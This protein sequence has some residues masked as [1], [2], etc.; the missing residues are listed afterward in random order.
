MWGIAAMVIVATA[1]GGAAGSDV[2]GWVYRVAAGLLAALAALTALTGARTPVVWFKICPFVLTGSAA[3]LVAASLLQTR[4]LA[5]ACR[6]S[7]F[8]TCRMRWRARA[9][10]VGAA[11]D[12]KLIRMGTVRIWAFC[13]PMS[14]PGPAASIRHA[15]DLVSRARA[16]GQ[17]LPFMHE[18]MGLYVAGRF[19]P[20]D[21]PAARC[22]TI[23]RRSG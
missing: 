15:D 7:S 14:E 9:A 8:T 22:R 20:A 13:A 19:R 16:G 18:R 10:A 23:V 1:V 12:S 3:L 6:A 11:F 2:R 17:D 21:A 5:A 4:V